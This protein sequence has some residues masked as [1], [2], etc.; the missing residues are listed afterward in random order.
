MNNEIKFRKHSIKS[1][2]ELDNWYE[3][4][5]DILSKLCSTYHDIATSKNY[6]ETGAGIMPMHTSINLIYKTLYL[7]M[8]GKEPKTL[9]SFQEVGRKLLFI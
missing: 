2:K 1:V 5:M 9:K 3:Q 4:E 8:A 7:E 6:Q